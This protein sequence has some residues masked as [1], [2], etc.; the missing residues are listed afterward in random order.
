[1]KTLKSQ[2]KNRRAFPSPVATGVEAGVATEMPK[3]QTA[4]RVMPTQ[5]TPALESRLGPQQN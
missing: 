5:Q 2:G 4:E 1:M 3:N